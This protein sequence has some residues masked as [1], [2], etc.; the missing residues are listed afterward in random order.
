MS[1]ETPKPE[2]APAPAKAAP[3]TTAAPP[4]F[5]LLANIIK[6]FNDQF[7]NIAWEDEDRLTDAPSDQLVISKLP[8][9]PDGAE[10][11]SVDVVIRLRRTKAD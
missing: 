7:G 10:I 2:A 3:T 4:E 6:S 5:D 9:A 11:A 8:E 1:D